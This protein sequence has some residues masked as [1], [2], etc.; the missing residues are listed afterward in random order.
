M[1]GG[2]KMSY[3]IVGLYIDL[4]QMPG[5]TKGYAEV[6]AAPALI[7]SPLPRHVCGCSPVV[8]LFRRPSTLPSDAQLTRPPTC[9]QSAE[10]SKVCTQPNSHGILHKAACRNCGLSGGPSNLE[11]LMPTGQLSW[12]A[13]MSWQ[14]RWT[15]T[16]SLGITSGFLMKKR[17][18]AL[19]A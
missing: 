5:V 2:S 9:Y 15:R 17:R 18:W 6:T 3:K 1:I 10:R 12:T 14:P 7:A 16:R 8:L 13:S 19:V 11:S 4:R